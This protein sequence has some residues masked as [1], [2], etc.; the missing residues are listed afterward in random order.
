MVES[1]H[2]LALM[3]FYNEMRKYSLS[4]SVYRGL[5]EEERTEKEKEELA[6]LALEAC[7]LGG[8]YE[9]AQVGG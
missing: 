4:L 7:A 2:A 6:L 8:L 5:K 9:D 1:T 3:S